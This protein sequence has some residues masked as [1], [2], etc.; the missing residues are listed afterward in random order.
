M[1]VLIFDGDFVSVLN[2]FMITHFIQSDV[3]PHIGV[4]V[5]L[6]LQ[7]ASVI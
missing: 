1:I 6:Y 7:L 2:H 3:S 4:E 5:K